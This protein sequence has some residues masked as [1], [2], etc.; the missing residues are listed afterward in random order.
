[1]VGFPGETWEMI[2]DSYKLIYEAPLDGAAF[3]IL[4]PLPGTPLFKELSEAH[5][6]TLD[7]I[8]WD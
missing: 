3:N 4:I 1:M 7:E 2:L 8:E 5:L 6:I